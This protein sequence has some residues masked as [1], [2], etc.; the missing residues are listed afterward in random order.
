M[1]PGAEWRSLDPRQIPRREVPQTL[2]MKFL[3]LL[4]LVLLAA[5]FVVVDAAAFIL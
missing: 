1:S 5:S 2:G 4:A 3:F